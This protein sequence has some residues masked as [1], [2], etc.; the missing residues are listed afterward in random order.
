MLLIHD[1]KGESMEKG[2]LFPAGLIATKC[3]DWMDNLEATATTTSRL[4]D[5]E[6]AIARWVGEITGND[7]P[8]TKIS[9]VAVSVPDIMIRRAGKVL[10]Y[11]LAANSLFKHAKLL[12]SSLAIAYSFIKAKAISLER[13]KAQSHN[14][15]V[16]VIL[17]C[18]EVL[19]ECT[20]YLLMI[21]DNTH[22]ELS[23]TEAATADL[24]GYVSLSYL[25]VLL[26]HG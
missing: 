1:E 12:P 15:G 9:A 13:M 5:L 19:V 25:K 16:F 3:P 24:Y 2:S 14:T 8:W 17:N 4:K 18:D 26:V 22:V 11:R 10:S 6:T 20:S 23:P 21:L 7:S